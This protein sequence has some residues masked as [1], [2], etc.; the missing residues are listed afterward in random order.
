VV[1]L[2]PETPRPC[3]R[4][5]RRCSER[6]TTLFD[7]ARGHE[8]VLASSNGRARALELAIVVRVYGP[9]LRRASTA[10]D[11]RGFTVH[12][13]RVRSP[14]SVRRRTATWVTWPG[15]ISPRSKARLLGGALRSSMHARSPPATSRVGWGPA[16]F[17]S[18][19]RG[20]ACRPGDRLVHLPRIPRNGD[21]KAC[22]RLP[23]CYPVTHYKGVRFDSSGFRQQTLWYQVFTATLT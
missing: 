23:G 15:L 6:R 2:H 17:S 13:C 7:S 1:R 10:G 11:V 20:G 12:V 3:Q 8:R 22:G 5:W 9:E 16:E 4:I 18:A 21:R 19:G 14:G